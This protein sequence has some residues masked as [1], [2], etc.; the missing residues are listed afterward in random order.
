MRALGRIL[1]TAILI[2]MLVIPAGAM[3]EDYGAGKAAGSLPQEARQALSGW[4]TMESSQLG[5]A[6]GSLITGALS[7]SGGALKGFF[8]ICLSVLGV[9]LLSAVL[10]NLDQGEAVGAMELAGVLAISLMLYGQFSGFFQEMTQTVDQMTVFASALFPALASATAATG[11]VGTSGALLTITTALCG[12]ASRVAQLVFLP[13]I[14]CYMALMTADGALGDGSLKML[15]DLLRQGMTTALKALVIG[16]TA[17]LS[18]TGVISGSA[19]SS[20]VRAAK[21]AISTAVPVVGSMIADASETL[22]V[23]AG[24]VRG[25][26]G[27]LGVL[28]VL[29]V[30]VGPF[31]KTGLG[32]LMLKATAAAAAATGEKKLSELISAQAGALGLVTAVTGVCTLLL[33]VGCVCFLRGTV[34]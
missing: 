30:S 26:L 18:L 11:A 32:Y 29:A 2:L 21:L 17:Y 15:G 10:R 24:M 16:I 9:V 4:E 7:Q 28:G 5:S 8:G 25:S 1:W 34:M 12:A 6:A 23:S 14:A 22:L 20:A 33:M 19:D 13:G 3:E 31:L 27:I